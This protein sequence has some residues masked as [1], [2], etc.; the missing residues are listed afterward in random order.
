MLNTCNSWIVK[1]MGGASVNATSPEFFASMSGFSRCNG[2]IMMPN[3]AIRSK[4]R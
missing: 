1:G 4:N 3:L 2:G